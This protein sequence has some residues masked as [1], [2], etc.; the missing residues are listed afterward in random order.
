[1]RPNK[2]SKLIL[3]ILLG[4]EAAASGSGT[5][6]FHGKIMGVV[7]RVKDKTAYKLQVLST[8]QGYCACEA[9][10][11]KDSVV[12]V[13]YEKNALQESQLKRTEKVKQGY[14][15]VFSAECGDS[16]TAGGC[17]GQCGPWLPE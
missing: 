8:P 5:C 10:P 4:S 16:M 11:A 15:G 17:R 1:M 14:D 6:S 13:R 7:N 3:L 12:T 9:T 2:V